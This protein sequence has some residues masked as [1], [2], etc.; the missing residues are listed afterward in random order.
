M[1]NILF[2][3]KIKKK[4]YYFS[5][6]QMFIRTKLIAASAAASA[7]TTSN[8]L[9]E[10]AMYYAQRN[11]AFATI[12]PNHLAYFNSVLQT[13]CKATNRTGKLLTESA[14]IAQ[15]NIDWLHTI[16]GIC[17]AVLLPTCT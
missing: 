5:L 14:Q 6:L 1:W 15:Y 12:T 13:P 17:P 11:P 4:L 9:R 16:E 8:Q 2:K 7:A 10:H 3:A